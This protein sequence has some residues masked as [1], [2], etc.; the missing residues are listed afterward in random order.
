MKQVLT[1][2][3]TAVLI[4]AAALVPAYGADA[5]A[6]PGG[7]LEVVVRADYRDTAAALE[8]HALTLTLAGDKTGS[9]QFALRGSEGQETFSCGQNTARLVLSLRNPQD[10]PLG[11]NDQVGFL[12]VSFSGLP[13]DQEYQVS[14]AGKGFAS[15]TSPKMAVDACTPHLLVSGDSG[16]FALGD[17]TGDGEITQEAGG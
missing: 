9:Q 7:K 1:G 16:G 14:L 13:M 10:A 2:F 8:R 3:L 5:G 12:L 11:G 6:F 17:L 4:L 15:F